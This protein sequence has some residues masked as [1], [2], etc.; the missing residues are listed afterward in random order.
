[1]RFLRGNGVRIGVRGVWNKFKQGQGPGLFRPLSPFCPR[2][3]M[4]F[5][6]FILQF[7]AT[8]FH[9]M[10]MPGTSVRAWM[11]LFFMLDRFIQIRPTLIT[12]SDIY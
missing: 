12:V 7:E 5:R 6:M 8:V 3:L 9:R 11:H 10:Q 4:A 2:P 1:M